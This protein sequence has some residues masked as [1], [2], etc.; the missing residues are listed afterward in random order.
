[1]FEIKNE[2]EH[3]LSHRQCWYVDILATGPVYDAK[4]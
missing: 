2:R 1:V 3:C 4:L